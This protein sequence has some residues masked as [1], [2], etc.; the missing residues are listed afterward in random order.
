MR[1]YVSNT[2]GKMLKKNGAT[3]CGKSCLNYLEYTFEEL[4]KHLESQF[5]GWMT[6]ENHGRYETKTWDDQDPSTWTWQLDHIVPQSDVSYES[7]DD[8]NFQKC[9]D[10]A[11]LRPLSAKKNVIDGA[12][13]IRHKQAF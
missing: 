6:W 13:L 4:K 7:M 12:G 1:Q 8:E 3:K 11:N 9:W 10:L 5:E 2:I